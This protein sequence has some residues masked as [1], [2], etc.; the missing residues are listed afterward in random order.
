MTS[1]TCALFDNMKVKLYT[2]DTCALLLQA[3]TPALFDNMKREIKARQEGGW[4]SVRWS[5]VKPP[6][7]GQMDIVHGRIMAQNPKVITPRQQLHAVCTIRTLE[8]V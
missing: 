5:M 7:L 4:K 6:R 3:T 8:A 2:C 1:T